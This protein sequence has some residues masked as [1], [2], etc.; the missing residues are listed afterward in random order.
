M[1]V[2]T[3]FTIL[4]I[5]GKFVMNKTLSDPTDDILAAQGVGWMKRKAIG[6]AT[7]TLFIKH[8]KDDNGVEH[9]D[10]N[11]T[12]TGGIPGT[13][14]E[15]TLTWTERENE[16]HVFG[17]VIGKSR[18]LK[19]LGEIDDDFLKTGWTPDSLEHGLVQSYVESNTPKSGRTWIAV[20]LWGI[21][22]INGERRYVRHVHFTGPDGK[23]IKARLVYDYRDIPKQLA[24]SH[25][26]LSTQ[27]ALTN[28]VLGDE[29]VSIHTSM[30]A[31][32]SATTSATAAFAES[33]P[34]S[35]AHSLPGNS[36]KASLEL[37]N[38]G[39][40]FVTD[41]ERVNPRPRRSWLDRLS[42]K[43][44]ARNPIIHARISR[45]V[46]YF[47]GPRPKVDLPDPRPFLDIN[48]KFRGLHLVLPLESTLI[49]VTRPLTS[50]WF[51]ANF[52][53]AW[54]I[55]FSF[56]TRSQSFL[57][58]AES[59][60]GCTS[61]YWLNKDGCGLDGQ[62]CAPFNDSS[63]DFRCP[64][65]CSNVILQN[66]RT[67]GNEQIAFVPLIVGGGDE[68]RTYRGDTFI[69]AAAVQAGLISDSR[70]GCASLRLIG[71]HTNFLPFTANGLS[72][73]GFPTIFP[74]S[75]QFQEGTPLTHCE[76]MRD[77]ALA[78]NVIIT[79]MI[80]LI[81]RPKP[82]V[83]FWCLV[84]I[85]FWHISLFS[86]PASSPPALERAFGIFLPALF[87][88]YGLWRLAWRFVLP[89]FERAPIEATVLYLGPYW[90]GVLANLTTERI[91]IS[92][93][94][95]S[96]I[97][98]RAG[99]I[100]SL[101]III[102]VVAALVIN[103]IRVIR[104]T[105]WLPHYFAWYAIGGLVILILSRLPGLVLRIHHYFIG[106]VLTPGTAFPTR[107]SALCQGLLLG[108]FLNGAAAF[109]FDAILQSPASLV[110]DAPI[111]SDLPFF[112]TNSSTW[113]P[114]IPFT[115][116]TISWAAAPEGWDGF[117]LLVD[118]VER[119]TRVDFEWEYRGLH[120]GRNALAKWE[121]D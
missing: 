27:H 115:N 11:Q 70:G 35:R 53:V 47:V 94:L 67:V 82:I 5:T 37:G 41:P 113:N 71:N 74:L 118:D 90:V 101:V 48:L 29:L 76:D 99:G 111:G 87:I 107:I 49:R 13:R 110:R 119:Y 23:I 42:T 6:L 80:F 69:C 63:F 56:F 16:D 73:I 106:M 45:I 121:L 54:I 86:Q 89:A 58:P 17:S 20:Q 61:T 2:P 12:L 65:Q 26:N 30:A 43:L 52:V 114:Q 28:A 36:S 59:F 83:K 22:E 116:Q 10:I 100:T 46:R 1:A 24:L 91:P 18:R 15:R 31:N 112:L 19:D 50:P 4:D 81:F 79:V 33:G 88:A 39:A 38:L 102:L 21:E 84:C 95:S 109:G 103:Q 57:T 72:S 9:I 75:W 78:L 105:G 98:Q 77:A 62:S 3:E 97:N 60:I 44:E 64:A 108:L 7:I 85:G 55:G 40:S 14:E 51:F 32:A 34:S 104:K 120:D 68:E 92:R 117:S 93:L 66:P 8:Y 25:I 96:D